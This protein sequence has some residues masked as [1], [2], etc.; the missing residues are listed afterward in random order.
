MHDA[1]SS[2]HRPQQAQYDRIGGT[3]DA[4]KRLPLARF[5]ERPSVLRLMG[6]MTGLRV[7]DLACGSG[8]YSRAARRLGAER[9]V[10]VDISAEMV[11][12]AAEQEEADRLGIEYR[13]GDATDLPSLGVFDVVLGIY[14]LNYA[15][16]PEAMSGMAQAVARN[17][18]PGG[19][20]RSLNARPGLDLDGP[21]LAKYGFSFERVQVLPYGNEVRVTANTPKPFDFRAHILHESVYED[22]FSGAGFEKFTWRPTE[23]SFEGLLEFGPPYWANYFANPPWICFSCVRSGR[24]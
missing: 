24:P 9:V 14:L 3:Y 22:A 2:H 13:V 12:V 19:E 1:L 7:L 23:L 5:V 11:K 4:A 17:L 8:V 16:S 21:G 18:R 15:S 10:G 6:D 20:F